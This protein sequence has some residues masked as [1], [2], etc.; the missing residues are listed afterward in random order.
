MV[1][2]GKYNLALKSGVVRTEYPKVLLKKK[3]KNW[4]QLS[5]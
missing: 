2:I 1:S 5:Q 4:F 3:K